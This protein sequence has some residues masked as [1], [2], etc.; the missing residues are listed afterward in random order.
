MNKNEK[1]FKVI[2]FTA[3]QKQYYPASMKKQIWMD[4]RHVKHTEVD[5]PLGKSRYGGPVIDL[6]PGLE[7]PENLRFAAQIGLSEFSA[8]DSSGLLPE[9]GHLF[10]F[11][12]LI[13]DTGKVFYV[14]VPNDQLVRHIYEHEDHFFLGVLVDRIFAEEESLESRFID[15]EG[16]KQWD[17]FAGSDQSKIF[18]I[19]THC[20]YSQQEIEAVT[21]SDKILLLQVGEDGFND[22]GVFSVLIERNDL[23]R[24][25]FEDC[26]FAWGQS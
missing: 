9:K 23:E 18:G 25:N 6:P 5:I 21:F 15:E 12:N 8:Y 7:H 20:Q 13:D 17:Y 22:E 14:D 26:E 19:Y 2:R 3:D 1:K 16:E 11:S 4:H 10:F 24:L